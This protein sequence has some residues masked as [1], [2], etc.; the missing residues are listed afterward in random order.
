MRGLL[1]AVYE[2]NVSI[3]SIDTRILVT[4]AH[5]SYTCELTLR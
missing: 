3:M 5:R 4:R 1:R 2:E